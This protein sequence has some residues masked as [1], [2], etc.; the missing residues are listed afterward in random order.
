MARP[1]FGMASLED[2]LEEAAN[3]RR[4]HPY[5]RAFVQPWYTHDR[6]FCVAISY[7]LNMPRP[8]AENNGKPHY[9]RLVDEQE[10]TALR[11]SYMQ[12]RSL[13]DKQC[14]DVNGHKHPG[15]THVLAEGDDGEIVARDI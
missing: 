12:L 8:V 6:K 14:L 5:T 1:L 15:I 2:A 10:L 4:A 11:Q 3:Y 9:F 7:T 13:I